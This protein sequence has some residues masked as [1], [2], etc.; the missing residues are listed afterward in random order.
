MPLVIATEA[1]QSQ[2]PC[3]I[4]CLKTKKAGFLRKPAFLKN[5]VEL[6][7]NARLPFNRQ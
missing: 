6:V 7:V 5:N 3:I 2:I 4:A 1:K